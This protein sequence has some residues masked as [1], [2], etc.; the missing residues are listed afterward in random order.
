M[1]RMFVVNRGG[2]FI[3]IK[4]LDPDVQEAYV[5]IRRRLGQPT[6]DIQDVGFDRNGNYRYLPLPTADVQAFRRLE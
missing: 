1:E 6:D 3:S 5:E 2:K 4:Q